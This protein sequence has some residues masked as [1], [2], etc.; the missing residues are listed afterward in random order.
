MSANAENPTVRLQR[1]QNIQRDNETTPRVSWCWY[2]RQLEMELE[3]HL[4]DEVTLFCST[5]LRSTVALPPA[6]VSEWISVWPDT[7]TLV[8]RLS[9]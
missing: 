1:S 3:T 7:G 2:C 4:H 9:E 6:A 5:C 8:L